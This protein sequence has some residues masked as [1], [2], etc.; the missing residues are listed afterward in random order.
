MGSTAGAGGGCHRRECR[1]VA[2]AAAAVVA[3]V[4][5]PC[6]ATRAW[7]AGAASWS[8][9]VFPHRQQ[10]QASVQAGA[11]HSM[12]HNRLLGLIGC[13]KLTAATA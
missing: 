2:R 5:Q 8:A 1:L 7:H 12:V 4:W 11:T 13:S 3:L 10:Q 9:L 6:A